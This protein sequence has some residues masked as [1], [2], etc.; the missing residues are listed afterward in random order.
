[1]GYTYIDTRKEIAKRYV[2]SPWFWIDLLA[3]FPFDF[4]LFLVNI[5]EHNKTPGV[6]N[7]VKIGKLYTSVRIFKFMRL[8][9][10][11][12]LLKLFKLFKD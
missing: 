5:H 12:R 8:V 3:A 9:K 7:I 1:M 2:L 10:F 4:I 6:L 11:F